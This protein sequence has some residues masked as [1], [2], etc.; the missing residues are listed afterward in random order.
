[1]RQ[2][3]H[4][5]NRWRRNA[6][7]QKRKTFEYS[8]SQTQTSLDREVASSQARLAKR[9]SMAIEARSCSE[10]HANVNYSKEP[11]YGITPTTGATFSNARG[12]TARNCTVVFSD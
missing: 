2:A 9:R 1:M 10:C 12:R 7:R 5:C 3:E 6:S 8:M 11:I 4:Q